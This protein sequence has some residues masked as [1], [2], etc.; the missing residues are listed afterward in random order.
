MQW[1]ERFWFGCGHC[2][3]VD[4]CPVAR[5]AESESARTGPAGHGAG[6]VGAAVVVFLM[7]LI[8]AIVG[9]WLAGGRAAEGSFAVSAGWQMAGA[10]AGLAAGVVT[11]RWLVQRLWAKRGDALGDAE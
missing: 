2:H 8:F 4:S 11:A 5:A 6:L 9:A 1:L 7:P 3:G 10:A